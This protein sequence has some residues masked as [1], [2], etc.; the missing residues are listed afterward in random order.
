MK[1]SKSTIF[2]TGFPIFLTFFM[3]CFGQFVPGLLLSSE[4][5]SSKL[6]I[7]GAHFYLP[8]PRKGKSGSEEP[9]KPI[10]TFL[11]L[12]H[13]CLW[14]KLTFK[15]IISSPTSLFFFLSPSTKFSCLARWKPKSGIF[16]RGNVWVGT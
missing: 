7:S 2:S 1:I 12:V 5:A 15:I 13:S 6:Y 16:R 11:P 10:N 4:V 9:I 8:Q 14:R 3:Q